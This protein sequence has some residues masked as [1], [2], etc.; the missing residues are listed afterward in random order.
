MTANSSSRLIVPSLPAKII[1]MEMQGQISDGMWENARPLDHYKAWMLNEEQVIVD[2]NVNNCGR[3][4]SVIKDN[5]NLATH[6]LDFLHQE[7]LQTIKALPGFE[8][9]TYHD[10]RVAIGQLR[11]A[12][13]TYRSFE[14]PVSETPATVAKVEETKSI[15]E[16]VKVAKHYKP[17]HTV[18]GDEMKMSSASMTPK[19]SSFGK[20]WFDG[21]GWYQFSPADKSWHKVSTIVHS[22]KN[23]MGY[24]EAADLWTEENF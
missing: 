21:D 6:E 9:F 5:Y 20:I 11:N 3:N 16:D 7:L 18:A 1:F 8:G 12:M 2:P 4:F 22:N 14:C 23:S 19:F 10:L 15:I 17:E 24:F 13:K